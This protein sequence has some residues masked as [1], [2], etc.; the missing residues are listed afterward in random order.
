MP[1]KL[2]IL[3]FISFNVILYAGDSLK[4]Y[5]KYLID[6]SYSQKS[7]MFGNFNNVKYNGDYDTDSYELNIANSTSICFQYRLSHKSKTANQ[8]YAGIGLNYTTGKL[9][10]TLF[11]YPLTSGLGSG[12]NR[13]YSQNEF[14]YNFNVLSICP[15]LVYN[16]IFKRLILFNKLG[17]NC[18]KY[19]SA[20]QYNYQEQTYNWGHSKDA[21]YITPDNPDGWYSYNT[22]ESSTNKT[23]QV[24]TKTSFLIFYN[25]GLGFRIGKFVP[26]VSVEVNQ[27]FMK[28]SFMFMKLQG[29][30]SYLF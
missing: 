6:L 26:N 3:F 18:S 11:D 5:P 15:Q 24:P 21:S 29:G 4:T 16:V 20:Q 2:F 7:M 12:S 10:H 30:L 1:K 28:P 17:I 14:N 13:S 8:L 25:L 22:L 19:V 9:N 23:D 27:L